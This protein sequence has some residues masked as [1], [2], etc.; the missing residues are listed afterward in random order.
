MKRVLSFATMAIFSVAG[1]VA[2][3]GPRETLIQ[4]VANERAA[5]QHKPPYL[6]T[7]FERSDRTG[8]KLW[9]ERVAEVAE[10]RVRY[11][12]EEDGKPLDAA[13]QQAELAKLKKIATDPAAFIRAEQA[14]KN[15]E[16][17][18]QQM[19]ELLPHAF[20][21]ELAGTDGR[22]TRILYKPNPDYAP[23]NYEER[24][25]H[26]MSGS[27]LV[28]TQEIRLHSLEGKLNDDVSFGYGLLATI[29]SGSNFSTQRDEVG[30]GVWKTVKVE[31]HIDGRAIFFKTIGRQQVS[32]HEAFKPLPA[33]TTLAQAVAAVMQ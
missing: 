23:Q 10:G 17:H 19:L 16:K 20:L 22:Y 11:L 9:K 29:H 1:V 8:G 3:P 32:N 24:V 18:A 33:E 27:M 14:R 15:D 30:Q 31:T 2:Q 7:S 26:G 4:V 12:L 6:Y 25:L 5:L 28:D 21:F 13:R